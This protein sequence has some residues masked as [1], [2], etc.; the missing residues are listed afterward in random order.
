[1]ERGVK[2]TPAAFTMTGD[3]TIHGVTKSV[4]I[5][6]KLDGGRIERGRQNYAYTGTTTI[7]RRDFGMSLGP[8]V[9]GAL[10]VGYPVTINFEAAAVAVPVPTPAPTQ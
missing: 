4:S 9:D 7:D 3:L 1:M 8:I 2:G 5:A 10:F 6:C